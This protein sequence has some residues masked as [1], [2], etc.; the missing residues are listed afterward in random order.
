MKLSSKEI[1]TFLGCVG[2]IFIVA[3]LIFKLSLPKKIK[4]VVDNIKDNNSTSQKEE[5]NNSNNNN[6]TNGNNGEGSNNSNN[7][8][9]NNGSN[10]GANNNPNNGGVVTKPVYLSSSEAMKIGKD[11][12]SKAE[13]IS[14]DLLSYSGFVFRN[15]D[16]EGYDT[17]I[18]NS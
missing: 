16:L 1:F 18:I 8:G 15:S 17:K 12:Y 11:L 10:G 13:I 5:N 2:A 6:N 7:P 9:T 14:F 4:D 3:F